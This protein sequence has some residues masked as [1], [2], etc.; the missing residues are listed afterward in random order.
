[1]SHGSALLSIDHLSHSYGGEQVLTDVSLHICKGDCLALVGP[2]GGGKTTLLKIIAGLLTP[3][4]GEL[5]L[6]HITRGQIGYVPQYLD[7]QV[8][9]P[10]TALE[11]VLM[12]GLRPV[13]FQRRIQKAEVDRAQSLMEQLGVADLTH[14]RLE[15]LSG[16]QRQ[17]VLIARALMADPELLLFDEPTSNIDPEGRY[18]FHEVLKSLSGHKT[19]I[20]VSHDFSVLSSGV[21]CL[22]GVN[23][24]L[25]YSPKAD[26]TPEVLALVYGRHN[27]DCPMDSYLR[28]LSDFYTQ[29]ERH[30]A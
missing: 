7:V 20:V 8:G 2:N 13:W 30:H 22:A 12:G 24:R 14:R 15:Q 21:T 3:S 9:F 29:G 23:G 26:L 16:G 5:H 17:R 1:M 6:E 19:V 10:I 11:V 18:C 27:K 28:G 25:V 4:Q